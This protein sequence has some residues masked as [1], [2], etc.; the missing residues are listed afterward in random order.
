MNI[1]LQSCRFV[2]LFAIAALPVAI[3][4]A[5]APPQS[6]HI[7]TH[8]N[9]LTFASNE[10][11]STG[12]FVDHGSIDKEHTMHGDTPGVS[13]VVGPLLGTAGTITWKFHKRYAP[14]ADPAV[15][16]AEGEFHIL[17][18]TGRYENIS[19]HGRVEGVVN[20]VTGET[21]DSFTGEVQLD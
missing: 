12:A 13:K 17:G 3:P 21:V 18:G 6:L 1:K 16:T 4:A 14:T 5:A 10:W 2:A 20:V 7:E 9:F 8:F 11:A 19:G 15:Y